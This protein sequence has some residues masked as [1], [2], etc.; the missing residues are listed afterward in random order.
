MIIRLCPSSNPHLPFQHHTH[1]RRLKTAREAEQQ[2]TSPATPVEALREAHIEAEAAIKTT[3]TPPETSGTS[4][5]EDA[6]SARVRAWEE[7]SRALR[8]YVNEGN[9][10]GV[11]KILAES[12]VT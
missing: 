4:V 9:T 6:A 5:E 3:K 12:E 8:L 1:S 7:T 11:G 10:D 2:P